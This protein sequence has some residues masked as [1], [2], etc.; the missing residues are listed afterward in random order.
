[1]MHKLESPRLL[2]R[3]GSRAHDLASAL[4]ASRVIARAGNS[5]PC[6]RCPGDLRQV[7]GLGA[8]VACEIYAALD[9][10]AHQGG[11]SRSRVRCHGRCSALRRKWTREAQGQNV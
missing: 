6:V 2:G 8:I 5:R 11:S 10:G 9:W 4:I 3:R 1:M 7:R